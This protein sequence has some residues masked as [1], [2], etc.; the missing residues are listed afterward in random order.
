[1]RS[2]LKTM[3]LAGVLAIGGLA[4]IH[5]PAHAGCG[6]GGYRS[7]GGYG[8]GHSFNAGYNGGTGW[9]RLRRRVRHGRDEHARDE[10][11]GLRLRAPGRSELR[12]G[13]LSPGR[14]PAGRGRRP[15][16]LPDAPV[17]RQ[18]DSGELPVLPH[19]APETLI[20][21][22]GRSPGRSPG[23]FPQPLI[24]QDQIHADDSL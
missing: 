15:V 19:G 13:G 22:T 2:T 3:A 8:G 11:G 9:G 10:H 20:A 12:P 24:G 1:M 5:V 23:S 14:S 21:R 7:T 6:G 16:H 17:G 18:R 4:M